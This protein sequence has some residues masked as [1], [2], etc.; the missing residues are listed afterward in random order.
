[1]LVLVMGVPQH[2]AHATSLAAILPIAAAGAT[3]FAL[4]DHINYAIGGWLAVGAL[5]GAPLG[6]RILADVG[7]GVLKIAFGVLMIVVGAVLV[8]A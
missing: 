6:A 2:E 7:E 4:A 5:L 1:M 3:R 8:A